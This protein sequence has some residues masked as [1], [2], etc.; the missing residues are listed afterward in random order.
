MHPRSFNF[1]KKYGEML[2]KNAEL[3]VKSMTPELIPLMQEENKLNSE[4]SAPTS[5]MSVTFQG[6]NATITACSNTW[7]AKIGTFAAARSM[8][9]P[10]GLPI[11][12][13]SLASFTI[14]WCILGTAWAR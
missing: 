11:M 10:D 7:K 8:R 9:G 6:E 4:Y 12:K 14:S 13:R 1:E 2:I 5:S 3:A